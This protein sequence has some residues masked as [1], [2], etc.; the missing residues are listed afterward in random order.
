MAG[1]E[2]EY[3][4]VGTVQKPHGIRGELSV[5]VETD[6][7]DAVFTPGRVLLLGDDAGI[8]DGGTLTVERARP[9][10]GGFLL[11]AAGLSSRTPEVEALR[12]RTL[13]IPAAEAAPL[14]EGEVFFHHLV[15]MRVVAAGEEVGR[16]RDVYEAPSGHLLAVERRGR[17]ELMLP[18][19]REM[20]RRVDVEGR[21]LEIDPP[22]GL[23]DL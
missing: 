22:A 10:K 18:F 16:V 19:V 9:F 7:P 12:G 14:D 21:E 13:L 23:L 1:S 17:K 8:P 15:G 4:A 3:L 2:P 20:V 11:K 6:R 5:R